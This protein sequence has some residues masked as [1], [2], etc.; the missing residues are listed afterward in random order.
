MALSGLDES[1]YSLFDCVVPKRVDQEYART[2]RLSALIPLIA[3]DVDEVVN[4]RTLL[5]LTNDSYFAVDDIVDVSWLSDATSIEGTPKHSQLVTVVKNISNLISGGKLDVLSLVLEKIVNAPSASLD[6]IMTALRGSFPARKKLA[7][8]Q[9]IL[10]DARE[11]II[12]EGRSPD[13]L[14]HGLDGAA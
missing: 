12:A 5:A 9:S 8:W 10:D 2:W 14:L 6:V 7:N 4:N 13:T 3:F 1:D 11:R